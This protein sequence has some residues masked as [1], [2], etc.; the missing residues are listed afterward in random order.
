M[1]LPHE[2]QTGSP[3]VSNISNYNEVIIYK[4]ESYGLD[5]KLPY[6][7]FLT[8]QM[9]GCVRDK[10]VVVLPILKYRFIT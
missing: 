10:V 7:S 4:H 1:G 9:K 6:G 5:S 3:P 8:I 2:I